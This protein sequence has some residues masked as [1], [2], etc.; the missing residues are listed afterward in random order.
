MDSGKR[1]ANVITDGDRHSDEE[2]IFLVEENAAEPMVLERE[3]DGKITE[4]DSAEH[5]T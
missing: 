4:D 2:D 1:V 3:G 5:G